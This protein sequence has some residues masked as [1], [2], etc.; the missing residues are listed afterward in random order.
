MWNPDTTNY[1]N[2]SATK[3]LYPGD[4]FVDVIG[5]DMYADMY[6][7]Q[8]G[9][10]SGLYHDWDTGQEDTSTAQ[11]M[12]D[13]INREHYWNYP[14][15]TEY[16]LDSSGGHSLSFAALIAF[17]LQ[18]NKPFAVP[19]AGSGNITAGND[20]NDDAAFPLWLAQTLVIAEAQGLKLE[21]VT[22]WDSNGSGN[23][24]YSFPSDNKPE[25]CAAWAKYFGAQP[26]AMGASS[27]PPVELGSGPDIMVMRVAEDAWNGDAQYTVS[28]DGTQVGGMLT[29]TASYAAGQNQLVTLRGHWGAGRHTLTV[30]YLNDANDGT[31][32]A[33]RNLYVVDAGYNGKVL[34]RHTLFLL[35]GGSQSLTLGAE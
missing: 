32:E 30:N 7:Y 24:E 2:A 16:S 35:G 11:F 12:A 14:A 18:H 31:I 1:T 13:P 3:N 4:E 26:A 28:V 6:P 33:D 23:Y 10:N 34:P 8:D 15:A 29:A 19:E 27:V 20:I 22:I 25:E 17:A 5:A 9:Y 21:F